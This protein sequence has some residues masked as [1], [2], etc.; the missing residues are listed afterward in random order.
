MMHNPGFLKL[1]N[2]AKSRVQ[3]I[4][5]AGYRKMRDAGE[6]HVLVDTARIANGPTA[7]SQGQCT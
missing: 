2:D 6:T 1:V 5:L 3:E 4:D 7:T